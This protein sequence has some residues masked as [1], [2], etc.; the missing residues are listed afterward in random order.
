MTQHLRHSRLPRASV[1]QGARAPLAEAMRS[2]T[3]G[4]HTCCLEHIAAE[5]HKVRPGNLAPEVRVGRKALRLPRPVDGEAVDREAGSVERGRQGP[6]V[7]RPRCHRLLATDLLLAAKR[8]GERTRQ[9]GEHGGVER[10]K[11]R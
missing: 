2:Q 1:E 4:V 6:H 7:C 10:A 3:C 11:A 8:F 5:P 9:R